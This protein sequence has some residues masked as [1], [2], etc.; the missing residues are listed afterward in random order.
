MKTSNAPSQ[1]TYEKQRSSTSDI[2]HSVEKDKR[3]KGSKQT[4]KKRLLI[5]K[6]IRKS[7]HTT[8]K[9]QGLQAFG[10]KH[11]ANINKSNQTTPSKHHSI[12][13]YLEIK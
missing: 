13:K 8:F 11:K 2:N 12:A 6:S 9:Q 5:F 7:Q 1:L 3:A 4:F 10:F